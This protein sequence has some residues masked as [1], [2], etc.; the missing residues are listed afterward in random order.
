MDGAELE[1]DQAVLALAQ[2]VAQEPPI[3][4][5][6]ALSERA[7]K[8]IAYAPGSTSAAT[9]VAE[10]LAQGQGVCQDHAH[11]FVS[12]A[13]SLGIPARYVAGYLLA[14]EAGH[15]VRETLAWAEAWV[16][17]LGWIGFMIWFGGKGFW[18]YLFDSLVFAMVTAGTFGWLWPKVIGA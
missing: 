11:L 5:L 13:R 18:A 17:G 6:H 15:A 2:S 10:A 1:T 7:H 4:R 9:T 16:D 3:P 12:A 14:D 8:A